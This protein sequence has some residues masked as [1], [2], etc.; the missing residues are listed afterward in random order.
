LDSTR[1]GSG[2]S[3]HDRSEN[4]KTGEFEAEIEADER[5]VFEPLRE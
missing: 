3:V 2:H 5:A 4:L 1:S